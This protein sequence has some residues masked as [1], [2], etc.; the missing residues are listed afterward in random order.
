[1]LA[2]SFRQGEWRLSIAVVVAG[3]IVARL[4]MC[5]QIFVL[6]VV[7]QLLASLF[8]LGFPWLLVV[9]PS[10]LYSSMRILPLSKSRIDAAS[11]MV[12]YVAFG[13]TGKTVAKLEIVFDAECVLVA[14]KWA[15][16]SEPLANGF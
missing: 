14:A 6:V 8:W 7:G 10:S 3:E 4:Q 11:S 13:I 15:W 1:M 5:R 9:L 16:H 12:D 2:A